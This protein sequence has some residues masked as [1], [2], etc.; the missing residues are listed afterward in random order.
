MSN[1]IGRILLAASSVSMGGIAIWCMHFIG[2]RALIL[3]NGHSQIQIA[4]SSGFTALSFFLPV[5]VLFLAFWAVGSNEQVSIIRVTLG[6]T[7]AGFG[8]CGMHYLGQAGITNYDCVYNVAYVVGAGIIAVS[9]SVG[10]LVGF[11]IFR[12]AWNTSWWKRAI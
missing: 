7:L 2:N 12:S 4:Y 10:A 5:I 8:I 3:G 6:G 1:E 9:A 11:F